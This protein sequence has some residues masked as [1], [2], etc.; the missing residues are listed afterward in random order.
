MDS[1]SGS[2]IGSAGPT[3]GWALSTLLALSPLLLGAAPAGQLDLEL[4]ALR[5][6]AGAVRLCLTRDPA[7]FPDCKGDLTALRLTVPAAQASRLSFAELPSG[8][9]ALS[10][11][12]DENGN[13][14]LDTFARIPREGFGFSGNPAIRFGPPRFAQARF[15]IAAGQ[16]RQQIRINYIL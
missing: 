4:I 8:A 10:A 1:I 14:R 16:V 15:S 6:D 2:G 12:H 5:S 11:F 13:G 9:Y 3:R 7:A